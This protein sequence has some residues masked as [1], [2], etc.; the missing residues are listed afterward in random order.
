[1]D[2]FNVPLIKSL[3]FKEFFDIKLHIIE[4]LIYCVNAVLGAEKSGRARN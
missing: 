1:M 2:F 4:E 3:G